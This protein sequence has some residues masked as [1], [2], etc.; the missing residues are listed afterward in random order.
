[1]RKTFRILVVEDERD[2]VESI[3]EFLDARGHVVDIALDGKTGLRLALANRYDA[4]V[5]DIGL[6]GL[7]GLELC[8][9]LRDSPHG[10]L[11]ILMLT[12]RDTLDD[13][14]AGFDHG[15]DDYMVKPFALPELE[16]RLVALA[17]R[18][19]LNRGQ[20]LTVGPLCFNLNEDH[21]TQ[22]NQTVSINPAC[23]KLLACLMR[24][25]PQ[26]V[27]REDLEFVLWGDSPPPSEGLK[28]H[29]H[30]LRQALLT[31]D[32]AHQNGGIKIET[33]RGRGYRLVA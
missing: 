19:M 15:T 11:P 12:A 14:L 6:P 2:L 22:A 5:L 26:T 28:A 4:L 9:A 33:V 24:S 17:R 18:S 27:S 30:M 32:G 13:K 3:V 23:R 31:G 8:K 21:I 10:G 25:S 7:D 16:R 29:I 20:I 1:M